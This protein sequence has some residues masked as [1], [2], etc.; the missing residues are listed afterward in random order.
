MTEAIINGKRV[1]LKA[2]LGAKANWDLTRKFQKFDLDTMEFDEM[3][4]L[5]ARFIE[6]WEFDGDPADVASYADLDLLTEFMPLMTTVTERFNT[7]SSGNL[8]SASTS[9]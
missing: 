9:A 2:K 4:D 8:P 5:L 1:T 7:L 3:A 6:S